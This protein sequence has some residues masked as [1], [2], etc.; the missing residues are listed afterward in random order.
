MCHVP[1]EA[2]V[3]LRVKNAAAAVAW[4]ER[5]GY[6][7]EWE[8]HF[9]PTFPAFVSIA[10]D[11][12]ARVFLSEHAGDGGLHT[13]VFLRVSDVDVVAHEFDAEIVNQTWGR[14]VHLVDPDGNRLRVSTPHT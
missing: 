3:V 9:E 2:I 6:I 12:F 4:Y 10:R 14:E 1:D 8:H 5:L 11:G 7:K 13:L